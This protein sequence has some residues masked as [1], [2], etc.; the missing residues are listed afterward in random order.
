[1]SK[2]K[3][4]FSDFNPLPN[5]KMLGRNI[6]LDLV[7][8]LTVGVVALPLAMALGIAS[9]LGAKA[10][11]YGAVF[12]GLFASLFGGTP[13]QISGPTAPMALIVAAVAISSGQSL[14]VIFATIALSGIFQIIL[15]FTKTGKYIQ[16]MPYP[17][18]SGF[19]SG[20][21]VIILLIQLNP[22][23]GLAGYSDID[24]AI[25]S[26]P[27]TI[28]NINYAAFFVSSI[29]LT[30]I[31]L[32]PKIFKKIPG[33]LS[34]LLVGTAIA[35][36]FRL[37]IPLIGDIP[38]GLPELFKMPVLSLDMFRMIV[39]PAMTLAVIGLLDT[40]MTSIVVE[41][42]TRVRHNSHRELMGQGIGN[43]IS[44]M[45]GGLPGAGADIRTLVN[46]KAGGRTPLSGVVSAL[47]VLTAVL[48]A[49]KWLKYIP[50]AC[51]AA[52]LFKAAIDIID[53]K[54]LRSIFKIPKFDAAIIIVVFFLTVTVD[55]MAAV[56]IGLL[57]ACVLF[58]K[59]MGDLLN[60]DIVTL[61]DLD[62]S[63]VADE[64]WRMKLD[65]EAKNKV[66]VF[67]LN[68]PLFF[69][70]SSNFLKSTEK[71]GDFKVLILRMHRVP[72]ID[73]TGALAL[74]ELAILFKEKQKILMFS[75]LEVQ[76]RTFLEKM[77]I[78]DII[79]RDNCYRR[80]E[81]AANKAAEII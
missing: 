47:F 11:L 69:G 51:L 15:G 56:G 81:Q 63:W 73:T 5:F 1:M 67:Q 59:R 68:G 72:E 40:L 75:G 79:G 66:L 44:G 80:F 58:V 77:G 19:L 64:T 71:H 2:L 10:G 31:Y 30:L 35:L 61:N 50:V 43:F 42:I 27:Q 9:G 74:E 32:L 29:T 18:I 13:A 39:A 55:I 37:N 54:T 23:V 3:E 28:R 49:G 36:L 34:G 6:P 14:P 53:F 65:R 25:K 17:V 38:M 33:T 52:I 76:P 12:V 16:Y 45:F 70:A 4:Y 41:R 7:G 62:K 48:V 24:T 20:L 26:I 46:I 21:G 8:G 22:F 60:I 57:L 78:L